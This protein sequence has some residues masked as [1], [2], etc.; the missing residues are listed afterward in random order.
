MPSVARPNVPITV[1]AVERLASRARRFS[2]SGMTLIDSTLPAAY[3]SLW[4]E[5]PAAVRTRPRTGRS[6][7]RTFTARWLDAASGTI[8]IDFVLHGSGPA[9]SW[10][11]RARVGD[12]I[13][14]EATR[15]GYEV[16]SDAR[17]LVLVGDDTAIPAI[18][19]IAEATSVDT[20]ITAVIEVVDKADER[21]ITDERELDP[22]WLHRGPDARQAGVF[23]LNLLETLNTPPDAHWWVA[24]ERSAIR[25]MRDLV[26]GNGSVAPDRVSLNAHWRLEPTDPR[27]G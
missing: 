23:T 22:I 2:F 25:S 13:W 4:F 11:D 18:G 15:A 9:S 8:V 24:G 14:A 27:S 6:P 7:K 10:A 12:T 21:T 5:D 1:T 19:A 17:H 16:P 20:R 26:L 3:L